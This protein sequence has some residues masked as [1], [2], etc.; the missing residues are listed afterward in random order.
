VAAARGLSLATRFEGRDGV[1]G[2]PLL[3]RQAVDNLVRNALDFAPTDTTISVA[4]NED[5]RG[6]WVTVQDAGPGI[7]DYARPRIFDR[8]YSLPRP[9]SGRKSTGLGLNFVR[10]VAELH[11]GRVEIDCPGAPPNA[12]TRARLFIPRSLPGL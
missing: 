9:D 5:V 8:F 4:A 12:G 10:E 1:R 11:G 6:V 3:L 2:D 7:P